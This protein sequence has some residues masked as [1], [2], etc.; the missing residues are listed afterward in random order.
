MVDTCNHPRKTQAQEDI[1][2]VAASDI[3]N[4]II[5]STLR[6]RGWFG[7]KSVRQWGSQG[8]KSNSYKLESNLDCEKILRLL[9]HVL[10]IRSTTNIVE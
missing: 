7:G 9:K 10:S 3:A 2:T 5:C 1:D 8:H 4:S 6:H